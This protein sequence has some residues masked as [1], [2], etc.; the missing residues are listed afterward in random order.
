MKNTKCNA[1]DPQNCRYHGKSD[2][3][4]DSKEARIAYL[5]TPEGIQELRDK[6]RH[7]LADKFDARRQRLEEQA[8]KEALKNKVPLRLALDIDE[9]SGGFYDALR[10][11]IAEKH[12]MTREEAKEAFPD[13]EHYNLVQ[14]GWFRDVDHFLEE[15][16]EAE[17]KGVYR[18]MVAF[19]DMSRTLRT[20]VANRDVE[21]HVVTARE[22]AWNEDTRYWLRKHRVPFSSI[23]HTESKEKVSGID[24]Y[25]DDS[26]K[27]LKTLQE[28]GKTVIAFD[29]ATND[30]V[31]TKHRVRGWSEVPS[32][33]KVIKGNNA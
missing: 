29:N 31:D 10:M 16:H 26:D 2:H 8:E 17:R 32:V 4:T 1:K 14:S 21:I 28:H 20:L 24:V 12:G 19:P 18:K 6:G 11:S 33:L 15:F 7:E 30:H 5:T 13:P 25:I 22:V 27:Q 3:T 9:T 23:T